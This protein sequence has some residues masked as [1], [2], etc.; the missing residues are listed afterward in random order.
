MSAVLER[1]GAVAGPGRPAGARGPL[2]WRL[3][4]LALAFALL[5]GAAV[6]LYAARRTGFYFDE[7]DFIQDRRGWTLDALLKPHNEHLSLLPV[8]VYKLLFA[9]AG[10]ESH[11]PYRL[12]GIALHLGIVVLVLAYARRRVGELLA[13]GAAGAVLFVGPGSLDVLW[14]FQIGFL[15]SLAAGLGALLCLDRE[16]RRGNV[17]AAVL[18]TAALASSSLGIPLLVAAAVELLGRPDRRRRWPVLVAPV[19]LY[20]VWY[21][22]YGVPSGAT[23]DNLFA[24]PRYVAEAAAGA[25]G[26][27]FGLDVAWGRPLLLGLLAAL[28]LSVRRV[29][30]VPWRLAA[31]VTAP[32]AFWALTALARA[33]NGEPDAARYLYPGVLFLVLI[34]VEAARGVR[35]RPQALVALAAL[36]A[37]ATLSNLNALR[38]QAGFLRD[39]TT[40]VDGAI[41]ATEIAGPRV[42]PEFQPSPVTA[43]QIRSGRYLAA[44][45]GLGSPAPTPRELAHTFQAGRAAADAALV[46]GYNLALAPAGGARAGAGCRRANNLELVVPRGGLLIDGAAKVSVRR[47]SDLYSEPLA[48]AP[49]GAAV[50]RIPADRGGAPWRAKIAGGAPVRVCPLP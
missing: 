25:A 29:P 17:A 28:V 21:A 36:L 33:D 4:V 13:L 15:G 18:L 38:D 40:I 44:A 20:A 2:G 8:L 27:L 39:Q 47:W 9:T 1:P 12:A 45:R 19:V 31:L 30:A 6:F 24:G 11:V 43:P 22:A 49:A 23:A 26:A 10:L 3:G 46:R 48:G 34:A 50:L 32:L 14:S 35:A 7:W 16:D 41:A 5:L 42:G 37:F